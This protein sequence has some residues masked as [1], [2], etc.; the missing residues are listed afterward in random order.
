MEASVSD[1]V[2]RGNNV[3]RV[4]VREPGGKART[5]TVRFAVT[6]S[7]CSPAGSRRGEPA[8][9]GPPTAGG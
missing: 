8:K 9:R 2:R 6:T 5:A 4:T 3:L 7:R 1:G